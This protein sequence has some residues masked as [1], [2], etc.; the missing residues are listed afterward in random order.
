M[1]PSFTKETSAS[2]GVKQHGVRHNGF[3]NGPR[4]VAPDVR[5]LLGVAISCRIR[6]VITLFQ[7]S[8]SL[9]G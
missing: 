2:R 3:N 9:T 6:R 7:P 8:H 1:K 4:L 5:T